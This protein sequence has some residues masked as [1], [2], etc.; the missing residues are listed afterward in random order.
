[1]MRR[2][3][4]N[5]ASK[6]AVASEL[7]RRSMYDLVSLDSR[8]RSDGGFRDA[9]ESIRIEVKGKQG[10]V[11]PVFITK[12]DLIKYLLAF[13]RGDID[14]LVIAANTFPV[15]DYTRVRVIDSDPVGNGL[16][17]IEVLAGPDNCE[18]PE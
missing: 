1:M 15:D 13:D 9:N 18:S 16:Y 3:K 12:E 10:A 14:A 17:K 4:V 5:L 8:E 7:C 11:W 6:F 2:E